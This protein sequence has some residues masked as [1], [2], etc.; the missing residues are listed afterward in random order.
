MISLN[1]NNEFGKL[2]EV[3]LGIAQS[4]GG[5]PKLDE[6]YDPKS[7]EHVQNGTFP[8]E[9]HLSDELNQFLNV[10]K[11]YNVSVFRPT[12]IE[13]YNQIFSR[14]IAFVIGE[15]LV[16]SN[17]I[18][19]REKEINAIENI[20]SQ[21]NPSNIIRL[22]NKARIEGGDVILHNDHI[23]IGYSKEEDFKQFQVA[24]TNEIAIEEIKENFSNKKIVAFELKKSDYQA[25]ENALH[26]DCC[27]QPIGKKMAIIYEE[28]FKRKEDVDYIKRLFGEDKLIKI[29]QKEM[30]DMNSNVFSIS[31]DT[32]VSE[33]GFKRL[34][35]I[36][37]TKGFKVEEIKFSE[38]AKME[39]LLRCT[40]LPLQRQ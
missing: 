6:C 11:K 4:N 8:E 38:I 35:S 5:V 19:D 37:R 26:L 33:I 34:N 12:L 15:K 20:I 29:T 2:N 18:K 28:G 27:F 40:T 22:S 10:L 1:V 30:Y 14:D 7:R 25:K 17:I 21:I 13:D 36:L 31:E 32:I 16:V 39:G 3:I 9:A 24:R 23:F